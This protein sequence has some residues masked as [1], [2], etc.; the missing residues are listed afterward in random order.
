MIELTVY[1]YLKSALNVDVYMSE[2]KNQRPENPQTFVLIEK[3]GSGKTDHICE[4]TIAVQSYAPTV[5]E[6]ALLNERVKTAMENIIT[7][8]S[9]TGC[10]LNSDYVYTRES[11]KQPRYQA[12]FDLYHY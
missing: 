2:P 11:T 5:Y 4:A 1:N 12:V 10:K 8:D 7:V 9:V 6:A 3:T